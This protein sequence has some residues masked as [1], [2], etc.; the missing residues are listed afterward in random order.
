M[1]YTVEVP[2]NTGITNLVLST[3]NATVIV[4]ANGAGKT[5]LG[6]FLEDSLP[7]EKTQRIAAQKSL[8]FHDNLNPVTFEA[9][10]KTLHFGNINANRNTRRQARW[11]NNPATH[12]L[13]D[14]QLVLQAL[15]AD[16]NHVAIQHLED[17][18]RDFQCPIPTTSLERLKNIWERLLPHRSLEIGESLVKVHP[19]DSDAAE[20]YKAS[21]LSDGERAIFY[22][23]GQTLLAPTDGIVIIDE[24]ESHIHRAILSSLWNVI[25]LERPDCGFVYLT[26]DLDFAAAHR[27]N[28][29]FFVRNYTP[30]KWDLAA[31][32]EDTGLSERLVVEL[33]G[34]RKPI[35]FLEGEAGSLDLTIYEGIYSNF[36]LVPVGSC[37]AVIHSVS[38]YNRSATLHRL[39]AFGIVDNDSRE[40]A[41]S[42]YLERQGIHTLPVSEIENVLLLPNIFEQLALALL[43]GNPP[44]LLSQLKAQLLNRATSDIDSVSARFTTR[45]LDRRLKRV[46]ISAR[47]LPSLQ[48]AYQNQIAAID[49]T[50]IYQTFRT[51][52]ESSIQNGDMPAVLKAYDNKGLLAYAAGLLG[53]KDQRH[54]LDKV[55]RLLAS[56]LGA[57]LRAELERTLPSIRI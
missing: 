40:Q 9:A 20:T 38:S 10:T 7:V 28:Q 32:P 55:S 13:A 5:R 23:I 35:L 25:E 33:V 12:L 21:E 3:G 53:L 29:K 39:R 14:F 22:F 1:E 27:A 34:S 48:A 52:L 4:G 50:S 31:I 56:P 45:Q 37:D 18:K 57:A 15:F 54:L 42:L 19:T 49:P 30:M 41:D 51:N 8:V 11:A 36:S 44:S 2:G 47:D 46:E 17:R 6:V 43:C 16:A 26:H 24:P